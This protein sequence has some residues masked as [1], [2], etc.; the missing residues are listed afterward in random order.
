MGEFKIQNLTIFDPEKNL[1][2]EI[3]GQNFTPEQVHIISMVRLICSLLSLLACCFIIIFYII[4]CARFRCN[5][6]TE[7]SQ[8]LNSDNDLEVQFN[9]TEVSRDSNVP[10]RASLKKVGSNTRSSAATSVSRMGFG[11][12]LIFFLIL[13]NMGWS[14]GSFLGINGFTSQNDRD[15]PLCISQAIIQNYFD[16]S[17]IC[18]NSVISIFILLGT[19]T[20]YSN[21]KKMKKKIYIFFIYSNVFPL[22][23]SFG[24]YLTES[25]GNSGIWCWIDLYNITTWGYIWMILFYIFNWGNLCYTVYALFKTSVYFSKR[26][27]EIGSDSLKIKEYKFLTKY[28]LILRV[29]PMLLLITRLSGTVNRCYSMFSKNDSFFLFFFHSLIF[30]L[31]GFCNALIYSYFYRKAFICCTKKNEVDKNVESVVIVKKN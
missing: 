19:Q 8:T 9:S 18:W 31:A 21:I 20:T 1:I 6:K 23:L 14:L 30:S 25:Y 15:D 4:M 3:A 24:P 2:F 7:S 10:K 27:R 17:S 5:K 11:N 22:I 16:M 13:S 26:K 28:V 12:D 29:F